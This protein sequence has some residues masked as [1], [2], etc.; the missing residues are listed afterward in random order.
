MPGA[1]PPPPPESAPA[2]RINLTHNYLV[3]MKE[4]NMYVCRMPRTARIESEYK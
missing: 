3:K 2:V 4:T 1:P